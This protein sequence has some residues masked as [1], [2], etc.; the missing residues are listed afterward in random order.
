MGSQRVRQGLVAE[1]MKQ[2]RQNWCPG[3][4]APFQKPPPSGHT[5]LVLHGVR[6]ELL[7]VYLTLDSGCVFIHILRNRIMTFMM[8]YSLFFSM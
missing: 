6:H 4:Q 2:P 7:R 8:F 3:G 1:Q 5:D